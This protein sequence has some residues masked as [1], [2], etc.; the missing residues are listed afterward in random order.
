[1]PL[2]K[3]EISTISI[4]HPKY[5]INF[6]KEILLKIWENMDIINTTEIYWPN[7]KITLLNSKLKERNVFIDATLGEI[8]EV[9]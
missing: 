4:I 5:T 6:F 8:L 7:W 2:T 9:D 3:K 1:M